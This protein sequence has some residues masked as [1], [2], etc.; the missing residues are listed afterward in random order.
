[1]DGGHFLEPIAPQ[2]HFILPS[3]FTL[4]FTVLQDHAEVVMFL[5]KHKADINET[6]EDGKTAVY[7]AVEHDRVEILKLLLCE[8]ADVD[9]TD[10]DNMS[11][12]C[13]AGNLLFS[14]QFNYLLSGIFCDFWLDLKVVVVKCKYFSKVFQIFFKILSETL[15]VTLP[16]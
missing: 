16:Q 14:A 9:I 15:T 3:W 6:G 10:D 4:C 7:L 2:N 5:I 8:R 13:S 11:P 1:M 12:L